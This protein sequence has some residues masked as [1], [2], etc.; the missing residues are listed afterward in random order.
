MR[1]EKY[2]DQE[3]NL[4]LAVSSSVPFFTAVPVDM[5]PEDAIP[6]TE[7]EHTEIIEQIKEDNK[8]YKDP[9]QQE[10]DDLKAEVA[11]LKADVLEVKDIA[12]KPNK[13]QV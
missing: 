4:V 10:I 8:N 5:K 13:D 1:N 9:K 12:I 11:S 3:G 7:E 6:I 2:I